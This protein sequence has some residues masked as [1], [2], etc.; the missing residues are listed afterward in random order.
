MK[1]PRLSIPGL[2]LFGALALHI[3]DHGVNQP[4]RDVPATGTVVG[5]LGFVIVAVAVVEALRGSRYAPWAAVVAGAGT[6]VGFVLVHLLPEWYAEISD[7]YWDFDANALSWIL[8][9]LPMGLAA[10]LGAEGWQRVR[11]VPA[12]P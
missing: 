2:A 7:P 5:V 1:L 10:W 8:L 9:A 12:R 3:V 6:V 11:A 4:A